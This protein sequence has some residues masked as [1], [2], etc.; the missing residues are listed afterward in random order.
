M[1]FSHLREWTEGGAY[2]CT[3]LRKVC[4]HVN[5]SAWLQAGEVDGEAGVLV[6]V[7]GPACIDFPIHAGR[8]G[9]APETRALPAEIARHINIARL[10][11]RGLPGCHRIHIKRAA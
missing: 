7:P 5:G 3:A 4:R 8:T 2:K 6:A 1:N 9:A 11:R 10:Q